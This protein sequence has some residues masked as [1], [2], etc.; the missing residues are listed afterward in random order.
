MPSASPRRECASI[1]TL[2]GSG[3]GTP[4]SGAGGT[5]LIK[6]DRDTNP[7]YAVLYMGNDPG[8]FSTSINLTADAVKGTNSVTLASNPGIQVGEIVL[9]DHVTT[10]DPQVYWGPNH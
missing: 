7:S 4:G 9:V 10:N 3:T 1:C 6:A 8:Q 5:R 2:R